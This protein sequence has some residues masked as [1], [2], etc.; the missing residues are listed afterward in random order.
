[1]AESL[2]ISLVSQPILH[3]AKKQGVVVWRPQRLA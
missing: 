1:M 2:T 3:F